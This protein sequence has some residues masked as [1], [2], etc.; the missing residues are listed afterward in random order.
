TNE[1]AYAWAF[2]KLYFT[3]PETI[4][5]VLKGKPKPYPF[6]KDII[7]HLAGK[8]GETFAQG[9]ALEFTGPL[10]ADLDI[11]SR[12]TIADHAV[13]IGAKFGVFDAD[14]KTLDYVRSRTDNPHAV[15]RKDH[16]DIANARA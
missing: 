5:I 15:R 8:F 7:L 10:A 13:E 12:L 2:G 16:A 3:V 9:R 6:G 14:E 11:A 4:K 1:A